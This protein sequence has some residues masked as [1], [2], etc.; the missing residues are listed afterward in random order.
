MSTKNL[1]IMVHG[2]TN[3]KE[4]HIGG[5]RTQVSLGKK[6]ETLSEKVI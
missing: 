6:H 3:Y 2:C 5:W 1:G 4:A